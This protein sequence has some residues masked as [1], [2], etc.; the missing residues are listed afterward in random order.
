[1]ERIA[2][3]SGP[4][5]HD[6]D[7]SDLWDSENL[8]LWPQD[9]RYD[10]RMLE[11]YGGHLAPRGVVYHVVCPLSFL[12]NSNLDEYRFHVQYA[13]L[14][15]AESIDAPNI[16]CAVERKWRVVSILDLRFSRGY[17]RIR[18]LPD[19]LSEEERRQYA[20]S[21]REGWLSA[22]GALK[23][24]CDKEQATHFARSFEKNRAYIKA[25]N[26][27]CRD[28][29][30]RYIIVLPPLSPYLDSFFTDGFKQAFL[31][32]NLRAS[33]IESAQVIDY[34]RSAAFCDEGDFL[35]GLFL[36]RRSARLF[37]E[38]VIRE[39][40]GDDVFEKASEDSKATASIPFIGF[41]TGVVR[42]YSRN[43][44]LRIKTVAKRTLIALKNRRPSKEALIDRHMDKIV[45]DAYE[46]GFRMFDAGRIY[47]YCEQ[48][49]G[50]GLHGI[51][52]SSYF[53]TTKVSDMDLS[54]PCSSGDVSG[55]LGDSLR[56][57]QTEYVDAYLL[58]WPHGNW[59]DIYHQMEREYK[60]G[61]ARHLGVCN[62]GV[63]DLERL[64]GVCEV[65]PTFNQIECNPYHSQSDVRL[66]CAEHNV[67]VMAHTPTF[68]MRQEIASEPV[69]TGL[70][71]EK[72]KT[73]AQII[74]R[75]HYQNDVIPIVSTTSHEHLKEDVDIMGF[76]LSDDEMNL[77]DSLDKGQSLFAG[78][79]I[80]DP[81]YVYNL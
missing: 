68:R 13:D 52:R 25:M 15:P 70:A 60:E 80:D 10:F 81:L 19:T 14:L 20:D 33:G 27:Y 30:L 69:L 61:R 64:W 67:R 38:R 59:E 50:Q 22:N 47:G 28:H 51:D 35:N 79:G 3:G 49:I 7:F 54:R 48:M 78:I 44:M 39:V 34:S 66:W 16:L 63:N 77:I 72:G 46:C 31:Y 76:D 4:C 45:K 40:E 9:L 23:D 65:A 5:L 12:E 53:L 8:A 73:V 42:R 26:E 41:G 57:L 32:D 58:H 75:W 18:K 55:N 24:L 29:G 56:Y 74:L 11:H 2:I 71:R 21:L 17:S 36:G 1:M 37:T 62:F 6:F 43:R